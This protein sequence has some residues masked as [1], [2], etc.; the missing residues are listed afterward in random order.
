MI[1]RQS[2]KYL[3][4]WRAR[5]ER[6]Y[7]RKYV[8]TYVSPDVRW[9]AE[10]G[11]EAVRWAGCRSRLVAGGPKPMCAQEADA[12]VRLSPPCVLEVADVVAGEDLSRDEVATDVPE[13]AVSRSLPSYV[14]T[15]AR[16]TP[17]RPG[18]QKFGEQTAL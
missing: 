9:E 4:G 5:S 14:R 12:G 3:S 11:A 6:R 17:V 13:H 2:I 16:K 8:R 15:Y 1:P 10:A 18:P 7:V